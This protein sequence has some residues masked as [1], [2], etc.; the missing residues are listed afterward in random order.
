MDE[1]ETEDDFWKRYWSDD[2]PGTGYSVFDPFVGGGTSL[3][4]AQ[5]LGFETYGSEI[6]PVA[7]FVTTQ[8]L[9]QVELQEIDDAL[10]QVLE[11]VESKLAPMYRTTSPDGQPA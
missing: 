7:W 9:R 10:A 3:V 11:A 5:R 2:A 6:D 8:E 1:S 4:E